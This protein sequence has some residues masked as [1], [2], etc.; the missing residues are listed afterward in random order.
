MTVLDAWFAIEEQHVASFTRSLFIPFDSQGSVESLDT[1]T[2]TVDL[3]EDNPCVHGGDRDQQNSCHVELFYRLPGVQSISHS[4]SGGDGGSFTVF[5]SVVAPSTLVWWNGSDGS[6]SNKTVEVELDELEAEQSTCVVVLDGRDQSNQAL[7]QWLIPE[8]TQVHA[9]VVVLQGDVDGA[10]RFCVTSSAFGQASSPPRTGKL[11]DIGQPVQFVIPFSTAAVASSHGARLPMDVVEGLLV[12]GVHGL[13]HLLATTADGT[14]RPHTF[15]LDGLSS[16]QF[17]VP[18]QSMAF[19]RSLGCFIYCSRGATYACRASD[20]LQRGRND[21]VGGGPRAHVGSLQA[22]FAV[23]LPLPSVTC[24]RLFVAFAVAGIS[25][26]INTVV[27]YNCREWSP[28]RCMKTR[29]QL[30]ACSPLVVC[31]RWIR[32]GSAIRSLKCFLSLRG[33]FTVL[34]QVR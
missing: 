25:S 9:S 29:K 10:V 15:P 3:P 2:Q 12:V 13:A 22:E 6:K 18:I 20:L 31:F 26:F 4:R 19:V 33:I 17:P 28:S 14:R 5:T 30:R 21:S 32:S 7:L 24:F 1:P 23:K 11:I 34:K 27:D 16:I 8:E